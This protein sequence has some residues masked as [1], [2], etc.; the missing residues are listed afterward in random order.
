MNHV[1]SRRGHKDIFVL[2]A[3]RTI[4]I[5]SVSDA[6]IAPVAGIEIGDSPT[7][8]V[9]SLE[10]VLSSL[11]ARRLFLSVRTGLDYET[12]IAPVHEAIE[13]ACTDKPAAFIWLPD[14]VALV[15]ASW[16][17]SSARAAWTPRSRKRWWRPGSGRRL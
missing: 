8:A 5:V 15:A 9:S 13:R 7:D 4:K 3:R 14:L 1:P 16:Q 17:A 11:K 12:L 10:R 2:L 6:G